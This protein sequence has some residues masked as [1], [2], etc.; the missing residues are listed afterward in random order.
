MNPDVVVSPGL[1]GLPRLLL[2]TADGAHAEIYLH[3]AHVASWVPAGDEERLYVSELAE[4]RPGAA[5]RGGIPV[6]FPQ[7]SGRGP[8]PRHGFARVTSW[9]LA[10]VETTAQGITSAHFRLQASAATR[11]LWPGSSRRNWR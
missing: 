8:L 3:G 10:A 4:F 11:Q 7:F 2:H 9:E 6:I 5:I 1:G